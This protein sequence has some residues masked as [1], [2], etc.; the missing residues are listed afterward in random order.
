VT[1]PVFLRDPAGD[2]VFYYR[3]GSSGNGDNLFNVFN[4]TAGRWRPLLNESLH[5]GEGERNAYMQPPVRGPDG[6]YHV[7][8]VWRETPDVRSNHDLCHVQSRDLAK[9]TTAGGAAVRLPV[10]LGTEGVAVDPIPMDGGALNF[11]MGVGFDGEGR[12]VV[13]Y[14]KHDREQVTQLFLA[15]FEAGAGWAIRQA[16]NWTERFDF[17]GKGYLPLWGY[18]AVGGVFWRE[19]RL[20][21]RLAHRT[22]AP[23]E[24]LFEVDPATMR[25]R[26][27]PAPVADPFE[28]LNSVQSAFPGMQVIQVRLCL[29]ARDLYVPG[30]CRSFAVRL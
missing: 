4:A 22:A 11:R 14:I 21:V 29:I 10:T 20:L 3:R 16:S 12:T 7:I 25:L 17:R 24:R 28:G 23:A 2:L 13:S 6:V 18:F 30:L 19:G 15:R 5:D 1:Y 9:W 27:G 26:V 8:W